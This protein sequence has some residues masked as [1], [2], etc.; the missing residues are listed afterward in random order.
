M[1]VKF[2]T[3]FLH[4]EQYTIVKEPSDQNVKKGVY[5]WNT[6]FARD[7]L[8]SVF[9]RIPHQPSIKK[10]ISHQL[11]QQCKNNLLHFCSMNAP[12]LITLYRRKIAASS[13]NIENVTAFLFFSNKK[14]PVPVSVFYSRRTQQYYINEA[15][16]REF[17][18]KYGL[19]YVHI[20]SEE[21]SQ[22]LGWNLRTHS[23]LNLL[24]YS[25]G[26]NNGISMEQRHR[27]LGQLMDS[28]LMSKSSIM[29]H[30]EWL[31]S[32]RS[33]NPAMSLACKA[34]SDDLRFVAQY[35]MHNQRMVWGQLV[36]NAP[37][38]YRYK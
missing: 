21:S 5:S 34:W 19:P 25:V 7:I 27:L 28:G 18:S 35:N 4:K 12:A 10:V 23:E 6:S 22:T 16:Y 9:F 17:A 38:R 15:T 13:D 32:T 26:Q 2:N 37:T 20:Q 29:D 24:G 31:I 30:L 1:T 36:Y 33:K 3:P 11:Y 8:K 14:E